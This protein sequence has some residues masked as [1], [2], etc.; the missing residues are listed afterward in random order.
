MFV[1][2][3]A[4]LTNSNLANNPSESDKYL[5]RQ[6]SIIDTNQTELS[7]NS[8]NNKALAEDATQVLMT[9][10]GILQRKNL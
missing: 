2:S 9:R 7:L 5:S 4:A 8:S 10:I 1:S 6:S 3:L